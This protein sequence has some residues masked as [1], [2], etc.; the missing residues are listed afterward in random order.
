M[1]EARVVGPQGGVRK[2]QRAAPAVPRPQQHARLKDFAER[3]R[4]GR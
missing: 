2:A 4:L 1:P 3:H